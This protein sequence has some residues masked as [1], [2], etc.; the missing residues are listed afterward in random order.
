MSTF[1]P[2][3]YQMLAPDRWQICLQMS[4]TFEILN[5]TLKIFQQ[6]ALQCR[7]AMT[8]QFL[9]HILGHG[10]FL[11]LCGCVSKYWTDSGSLRE[12]IDH[13][14]WLTWQGVKLNWPTKVDGVS[15]AKQIVGQ[16]KA[17]SA[18]HQ[19]CSADWVP[20]AGPVWSSTAPG[21]SHHQLSRSC[22]C[23]SSNNIYIYTYIHIYI[24]SVYRTFL[25]TTGLWDC[26]IST[27][28]TN[29][30]YCIMWP[31]ACASVNQAH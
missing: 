30:K 11:V 12:G 8:P 7:T 2:Q 22:I 6:Y 5:H 15:K 17:G 26:T 21:S 23:A 13:W 28:I 4:S 25:S 10:L 29:W 14:Q 18:M 24:Y 31:S 9:T 19:L 16:S 20:A 3:K 27:A 1:T